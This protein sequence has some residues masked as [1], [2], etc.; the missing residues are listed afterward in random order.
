MSVVTLPS[1]LPGALVEQIAHRFRVLGE[2][3]RIQLL[4][5]LRAGP[6]TV[7]QLQATIGASQQNV[8]KH[9]GILLE[10]GLVRRVKEG[11]RALYS[12]ADPSLF[13]LCE[14]VC[15]SL[16]RQVAELE[17]LLSLEAEPTG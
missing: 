14:M 13:A 9:L 8:S 15:G 12:I 11:N 2:P 5:V 16:R 3:N 7:A 17:T 10:A 4:D 6:A 1:P